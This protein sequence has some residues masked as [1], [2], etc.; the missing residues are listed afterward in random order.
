MN[1]IDVTLHKIKN[2]REEHLSNLLSLIQKRIDD[3][4]IS[5][6]SRL[7]FKKYIISNLD[8]ILTGTPQELLDIHEEIASRCYPKVISEIKKVFRYQGWFDRKKSSIYNVYDLARNIDIPTCIYCNR[9]YTKTVISGKQKI[10]RP[11]FDHWFT[12]EKYPLLALSFFNLIPSCSICNSGVKGKLVFAL[13]THF[14]PY[15]KHLQKNMQLDY[16][17]SYDHSDYSSFKFKINTR[18]AI[19]KES[20]EAFKLKE[21]YETHEDEIKDLRKIR[22]IYSPQYLLALKN[23]LAKTK[24]SDNEIYQLAFGTYIE[25]SA[26]DRRP[27]SRM[28]R[29]ILKELGILDHLILEK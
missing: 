28:K 23:T 25:E 10:T 24:I 17:F 12:K 7:F 8:I 15:V 22:D 9:M 3:S 19:S 5:R 16:S 11:S 6:R 4:I 2:A 14:H 1:Y 27:L 20:I 26:F 21:I 29:D 13:N 18:N